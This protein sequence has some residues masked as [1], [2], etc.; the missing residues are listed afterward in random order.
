MLDRG[1]IPD[2]HRR[3]RARRRAGKAVASVE[4]DAAVLNFLVK[5]KW[6]LE[7]EASDRGAVGRA[8]GALIRDAARR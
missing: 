8:I 2:R 7:A 5:L 1:F 3:F 6:L 4:F